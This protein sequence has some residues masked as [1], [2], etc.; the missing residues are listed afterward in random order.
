M[1]TLYFTNDILN[2][3]VQQFNG[4][5]EASELHH[6]VWNLSHPQWNQTLVETS[7]TFFLHDS[8]HG[9]AH[10]RGK[11]RRGLN[12]NLGSF[13]WSQSNIG[14][15]FSRGRGSQVQPGTVQVGVFFA[16]KVGIVYFEDFVEAE[17]AETLQEKKEARMLWCILNYA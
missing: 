17:F 8:G 16:Q 11:A 14:K 1:N 4:L 13:E 2:L 9:S 5:F 7:N 15:E 6:G 10:S 12:L 3:L